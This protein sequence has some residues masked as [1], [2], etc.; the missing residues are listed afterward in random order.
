MFKLPERFIS[1]NFLWI[2]IALVMGVFYFS[3]FIKGKLEFEEMEKSMAIHF[4]EMLDYKRNL[5]LRGVRVVDPRGEIID[6]G[7]GDGKYTVLNVWATW[8]TP[9]VRELPSLKRLNDMIPR[10][11]NLQVIA[12]SVDLSKDIE[13]VAQFTSRYSVGSIANYH[14]INRELQKKLNLKTLPV[15]LLIDDSGYVIYEIRGEAI[16]HDRDVLNF[17]IGATHYK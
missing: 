7:Y 16:W 17:L 6:L 3:T 1:R 4:S 12:V 2:G 10:D 8:C 11:E 13:N 15:T 5:S 9:C 14:D